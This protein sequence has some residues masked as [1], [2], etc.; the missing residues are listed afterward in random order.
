MVLAITRGIA[1]KRLS[2][3]A[4]VT[5]L[6]LALL[7]GPASRAQPPAR[8]AITLTPE[9]FDKLAG[10]YQ[11]QM[12]AI[13]WFRR[14]GTRLIAGQNNGPGREVLAE[15][16]RKL[17]DAA[18]PVQFSF[19]TDAGGRATAVTMDLNG[20]T[21]SGTRITDEAAKAILAR[22]PVPLPPPARPQV[23]RTWQSLQ[24]ITPRFV[25]RLQQGQGIDQGAIFSPDS[26]SL[27]FSRITPGQLPIL[28]TVPADGGEARL[29]AK[30]PLPVGATRMRWSPRGDVIAFS[31]L[32]PRENRA[33]TW[34]ID[35]DGGNARPISATGLSNQVVYPSW[36]PDGKY[37][38]VMDAGE[39]TIK[40]IPVDGGAAQI[41]T[42]RGKVYTGMPSLSPDG[43]S[44]VFAGQANNGQPY[45]Q[46]VNAIWLLEEGKP[47]RPLEGG[48]LQGRA[49]TWSPD[50]KRIAF[51]SDRGSPDGRYGIFI[52]NADGTGLVQVTD[53][54]FTAQH[55]VWS[56]DGR[57]VAFT[58]RDPATDQF[59]VAVI[60]LP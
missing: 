29:F 44:I 5:L 15:S 34:L 49:P 10:Y 41:L 56:P 54:A 20:N 24:G 45:D 8:P 40:R 23:A 9:E 18:A 21:R 52:I 53:Y 25:T 7:P 36:Y 12:G 51:E 2:R 46:R 17:Y 43:K 58:G 30:T 38:A 13:L 19:T 39:L 4:A 26:R 22:L 37:L 28:M 50:G 6:A 60:D 32:S 14:D 35:A 3:T 55:P 48:V 31:A 1:M 27:L 16:A 33:S 47:A 59:G 11:M 57:K 42:D